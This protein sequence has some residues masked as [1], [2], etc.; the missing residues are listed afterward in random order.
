M[1]RIVTAE[2]APALLTGAGTP[3]HQVVGVVV[4]VN[5]TTAQA[6]DG[7]PRA[8]VDELSTPPGPLTR[9]VQ[10]GVRMPWYPGPSPRLCTRGRAG[11]PGAA[12]CPVRAAGTAASPGAAPVVQAV[13]VTG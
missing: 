7:I 6:G 8:I 4:P 12:C 13:G 2:P 3:Q 10:G 5:P 1:L 11:F 9:A